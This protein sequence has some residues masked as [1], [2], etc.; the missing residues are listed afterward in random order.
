MSLLILDAVNK[1]GSL[2]AKRLGVR[3]DYITGYFYASK[4]KFISKDEFYKLSSKDGEITDIIAGDFKVTGILNVCV[5]KA[6]KVQ[7]EK[8]LSSSAIRRLKMSD[9]FKFKL[10][11]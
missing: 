3:A 4:C 1:A 6:I 10:A 9:S 7:L 5:D 8:E 2:L 11:L